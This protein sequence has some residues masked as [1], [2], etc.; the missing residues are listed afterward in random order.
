[1]RK[2]DNLPPS[3]A[4]VTK[5]GNLNFLEPSGPLRACNGTAF[6]FACQTN[7]KMAALWRVGKSVAKSDH[8]ALMDEREFH[9]LDF[10]EISYEMFK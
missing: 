3:C 5:Y 8:Q 10:R 2:A 1:V 7:R 4:G 6:D 9:R